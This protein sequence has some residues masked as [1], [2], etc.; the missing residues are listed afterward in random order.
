MT[1]GM[2]TGTSLTRRMAL[3][4]A[5]SVLGML[6]GAAG[7]LLLCM[8]LDLGGELT[9]LGMLVAELGAGAL[10]GR[11]AERGLDARDRWLEARARAAAARCLPRARLVRRARLLRPGRP[12]PHS[13]RLARLES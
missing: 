2:K 4:S 12:A 7:V 13:S 11:A 8:F 10:A 3:V 1:S 5:A 6:A 9:V